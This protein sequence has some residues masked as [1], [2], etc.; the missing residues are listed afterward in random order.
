MRLRSIPGAV[1]RLLA[2]G[3]A[4]APLAALAATPA[5]NGADT[6]WMLISTVLVLLMTV[7]GIM[8]FYSGMLRA[9]NGLS[10]IAHTIAATAVI[11]VC[12]AMVGYS[13]AF[14][15]GGTPYVGG[16]G[17]VF[18]EGL[19]GKGVGAHPSAPTI[20]ESVFFLFQLSFAII[21]FA[22]I[23]GAT[24]ERM[25]MGITLVFA[26][27]W[28]VLIY[29]PVAHW[30]W[31]P[32]G[33]LAQMGHM[34]F[35][36]GTVVHI[37]SG[38]SGLAAAVVLGPRRG[39][40]KEPM[41]PHNLLITVLGAGLLWA[42]WF[43]FNAGSAFEASTRAAGALLATQVAACAGAMLWGFC[44]FMRRGQWSV[45]GSMT[46]AIAGLIAVTPA[47]GFVGVSGALAIGS[48]AG[49]VCFF[50]VVGFKS[51]TGIDDS[52]DVFAL[53]GVGGMVG[54][55]LTPVF[56]TAAVA[57][58][59]AT[60]VTNGIGALAVM[61][62]AGVGTWLLLRLIGLV[63]PLRVDAEEEKVGL[64]IAQHGEM[65]APNA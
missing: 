51:A 61:A 36:G 17:R 31:H 18:A 55:L 57:P 44:E 46:G 19:V 45:L 13:I 41:V 11:T 49:I 4:G 39:F 2:A 10:I 53:H 12:W 33:W 37:A 8:L 32:T 58:V 25:R 16:L 40:G 60:V 65:L 9:K 38:V 28:S 56:A 34:D 23:L 47:S 3:L 48:I 15:S 35:A 14:T 22:L 6:A 27:L 26:A 62:Y 54:T 59:T 7:P 1:P 20:P 50:A 43:G 64:D 42:G 5:F 30:I 21:T 52:L 63:V 29:A 24:A